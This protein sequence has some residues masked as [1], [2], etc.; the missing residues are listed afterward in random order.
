MENNLLDDW[1]KQGR[2][3]SN[4]ER[5]ELGKKYEK[6][7]SDINEKYPWPPK[8]QDLVADEFKKNYKFKAGD[9]YE[10]KDE[11]KIWIIP[12]QYSL[13]YHRDE[14]SS[15]M[16]VQVT[17]WTWDNISVFC[18]RVEKNL[19]GMLLWDKCEL[20]IAFESLDLSKCY[21]KEE[22]VN[23]LPWIDY[24]YLGNESAR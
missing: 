22:M 2:G 11:A 21:K 7:L 16:Y 1:M 23:S 10:V 17:S 13:T 12:L 6:L 24:E 8:V 14:V 15:P 18:H 4:Q 9:I 3:L 5:E 19:F 20:E